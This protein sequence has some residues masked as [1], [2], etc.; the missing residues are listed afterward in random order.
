MVEKMTRLEKIIFDLTVE[1]IDCGGTTPIQTYEALVEEFPEHFAPL[2]QRDVIAICK[3]I[4]TSEIPEE[5]QRFQELFQIFNLRYFEGRLPKHVVQVVIDVNYWANEYFFNGYG[6][7]HF[8]SGYIDE[9]NKRIFLRHGDLPLEGLLL[10]EMAHAAT[11]GEHDDEWYTEM[12]RLSALGAPVLHGDQ[13]AYVPTHDSPL[14]LKF[15]LF[16]VVSSEEIFE[17]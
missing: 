2:D 3:K 10:H 14:Q 7:D 9:A 12:R 13:D 6:L 5:S 16:K 15:D 1:A 11:T 8:S 4:Q 17:G